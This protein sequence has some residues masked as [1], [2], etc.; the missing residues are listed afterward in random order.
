MVTT[1]ALQLLREALPGL[2]TITTA[3]LVLHDKARPRAVLLGMGLSRMAP[4]TATGSTTIT[5]LQE[6]IVASEGF[7][8]TGFR[9]SA[10]ALVLNFPDLCFISKSI[11]WIVIAHLVNLPEGLG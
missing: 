11:S 7:K 5:T 10:S 4:I 1:L 8:S 6:L 9:E 3:M 2:V